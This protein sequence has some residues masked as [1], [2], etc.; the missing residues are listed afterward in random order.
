MLELFVK[1]IIFHKFLVVHILDITSGR[2]ATNLPP[3]N[4]TLSVIKV[5]LSQVR[6]PQERQLCFLDRNQDIY[7]CHVRG[8]DFRKISKLGAMIQSMDWN[9]ETNILAGLQDSLLSVWFFPTAL[10]IDK[11]LLRRTTLVKDLR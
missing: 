8:N 3:V 4:H 2:Q 5:A 6:S 7:I 9:T 11:Y 10:Y 1:K